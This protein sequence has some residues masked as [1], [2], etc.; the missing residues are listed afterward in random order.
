MMQP[1][2]PCLLRPEG[3]TCRAVVKGRWDEGGTRRAVAKGRWDEGG[4]RRAE[5]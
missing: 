3:G 4:T 1:P 2:F 5:A